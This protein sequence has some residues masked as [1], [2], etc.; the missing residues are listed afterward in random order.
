VIVGVR[1]RVERI[2]QLEVGAAVGLFSMRWR[3]SLLTTS[4]WV[5]SF[6]AFRVGR[7]KP[8]RSDSIHSAVGN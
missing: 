6:F 7:R 3:R 5:A 4:R 8:I 2:A 1:L